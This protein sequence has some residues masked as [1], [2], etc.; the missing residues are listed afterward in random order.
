MK[1]I[2]KEEQRNEIIEI[3]KSM[4]MY[5]VLSKAY[6]Y[7]TFVC[8]LA[9]VGRVGGNMVFF[10]GGGGANTFRFPS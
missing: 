2:D 3:F 8:R 4:F 9:L 10:M 1:T 6:S 5:I 7:T